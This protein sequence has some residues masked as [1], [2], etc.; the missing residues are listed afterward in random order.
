MS[1]YR[2]KIGDFEGVGQFEPE[3]QVEGDV[4][5]QPFFRG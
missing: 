3:F 2:M 1:E 4:R 5:Q